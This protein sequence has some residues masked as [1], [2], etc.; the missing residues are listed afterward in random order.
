LISTSSLL[1]A[2]DKR[3]GSPSSLDRL[4]PSAIPAEERSDWQPKELVAVL[5]THRGRHWGGIASV[6][7]RPYGKQIASAGDD[8]VV[9]LWD[10]QTLRQIAVLRGH[11]GNVYAVTY[12]K[13][14]K[15]LASTGADGT[16][17]LWDLTASPPKP[18]QTLSGHDAIIYSLAFSPQGTGFTDRR[19]QSLSFSATRLILCSLKT[20]M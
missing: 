18:K 19:M 7:F 20:S 9:R 5:G 1:I 11:T 17:R 10:A 8:A 3:A 15:S 12:S 16:V 13:D 6:A 4:D 14:A 2:Q